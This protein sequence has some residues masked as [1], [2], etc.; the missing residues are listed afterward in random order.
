L[1]LKIGK[2]FRGQVKIADFI[3]ES[4]C[5]QFMRTLADRFALGE[6]DIEGV[7]AEKKQMESSEWSCTLTRKVKK[8]PAAAM[9]AEAK[10][11]AVVAMKAAEQ[12]GQSS[13]TRKKRRIDPVSAAV[14]SKVKKLKKK[15]KKRVADR[16]VVEDQV[17]PPSPTILD[18]AARDHDDDDDDARDHSP[19]PIA[20]PSDDLDES[21]NIETTPSTH[22]ESFEGEIDEEGPPAMTLMDQ[23]RDRIEGL[24]GIAAATNEW[25]FDDLSS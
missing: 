1:Q 4:S 18:D 19:S 22:I 17:A 9:D 20:I 3:D 11:P 8:R 13:K 7:N 2:L 12:R 24:D 21:T 23:A 16:V 6:F 14:Q 15:K 25:H 10:P 5:S